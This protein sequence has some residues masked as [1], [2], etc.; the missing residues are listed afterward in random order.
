MDHI[1][2]RRRLNGGRRFRDFRTALPGSGQ[3]GLAS[4]HFLVGFLEARGDYGDLQRV[5]HIFVLHRAED[6]VGV[7]VRGFL[8]DRRGFV[9]FMER[10]TAAAGDVDQDALR[11]LDGIV[12]KQRT[13]NGSQGGIGGA[14]RAGGNG[15]AHDGVTLAAHDGF[16]IGEVAIDDAGDGDD[17]GDTLHGLAENVVG[18]A[19]SVE[20]AG[21]PFDGFHQTL[22]GNDNDGVHAAD[23]IL[24][25][26]LCLHHAALAFESEGL[27]DHGDG[28]R[29]KF[30]G[31]RS[32]HR[33]GAAAGASAEAGGDENHVGAFQGFDDFLGIFQRGLAAGFGV[34]AGAQALGEF[35]AEL[36]LG[37]RLRK[38]QRLQVGVGGDKFHALDLG[39]DHAVDGVATAAAHADDLD[40]RGLQLLAEAH[41]NAGVLFP[42]EFFP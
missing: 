23:E 11:A 39:A 7:F 30:A 9:N 26:L 13:G 32:D 33:R 1:R 15:G 10:Q 5:F 40:L 19:E 28:E 2:Q 3:Q 20:E 24:Q 21:A 36:Q 12:F 31:K 35:R 14:G 17:V 18:D 4:L 8:D 34:G 38:P 37:G 41:A 42:N 27:G 25:S 6:D 16:H 22:V 29:P